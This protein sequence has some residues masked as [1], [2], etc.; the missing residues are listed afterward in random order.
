MPRQPNATNF[1]PQFNAEDTAGKL[2]VYNPI[3]QE[4]KDVTSDDELSEVAFSGDYEDLNN[5]PDIPAAAPVQSVNGRT[6]VVT[7]LAEQTDLDAESTARETADI[8]LQNDI[9]TINNIIISEIK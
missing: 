8:E 7:G 3:R 2:Q 1:T 4:Y 6:G 5:K 9:N